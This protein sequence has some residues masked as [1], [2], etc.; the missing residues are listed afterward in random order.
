MIKIRIKEKGGGEQVLTFDRD[1]VNIGRARGNDIVLPRPNIS[2][3]HARIMVNEGEMYVVDLKSTNGTYVNGDRI[4]APVG[5][6]DDDKVFMGDFMLK[7]EKFLAEEALIPDEQ[8]AS[9]DE[10]YEPPAPPEEIERATSAA[11]HFINDED[12]AEGG[13]LDVV[14]PPPVIVEELPDFLEADLG[15]DEPAEPGDVVDA[16]FDAPDAPPVEDPPDS[17]EENAEPEIPAEALETGALDL[18]MASELLAK[19]R[20]QEGLP[21]EIEDMEVESEE[22][23]AADISSEELAAS[24][25][26]AATSEEPQLSPEEL[27]RE[28]EDDGATPVK[29]EAPAPEGLLRAPLEE[30]DRELDEIE[31]EAVGGFM[32]RGDVPAQSSDPAK[33]RSQERRINEAILLLEDE[34]LLDDLEAS[35]AQLES[36]RDQLHKELGDEFDG[37]Q[38]V[39]LVADLSGLGA[40]DAFLRDPRWH[41]LH[42]YG[43]SLVT[44]SNGEASSQGAE[45]FGSATSF[46]YL[47]KRIVRQ[48]WGH[49]P[50]AG[51]VHH[52]TLTGAEQVDIYLPAF[53]GD[54]PV[55]RITRRRA[56]FIPISHWTEQGLLDDV[57][58]EYLGK[59]VK[60]GESVLV[61]GDDDALRD[62]LLEALALFSRPEDR[63]LL[64]QDA[65]AIRAPQG[66]LLTVSRTETALDWPRAEAELRRFAPQL[67]VLPTLGAREATRWLPLLCDGDWSA[68]VSASA[69]SGEEW[70]ARVQLA[71]ALEGRELSDERMDQLLRG[72]FGHVVTLKTFACGT[73]KVN[74]ILELQ[75]D[76][77]SATRFRFAEERLS[78]DGKIVGHFEKVS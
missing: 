4:S 33:T 26:R 19:M 43:Y 16:D 17:P 6:S 13:D 47:L 62:S 27:E 38:V 15:L 32:T 37:A 58:A 74:G 76:G 44:L 9:A 29:T 24:A 54:V 40:I 64:A 50:Q 22:T 67:V 65:M 30:M 63:L 72:V 5:V 73:Q 53:T 55:L 35:E 1:T 31:R 21:K 75:A 48:V 8:I 66:Q 2:K 10:Y 59:L 70:L 78:P 46:S 68:C 28:A 12:P 34:G 14:E 11:M 42:A 60:R 3:R 36:I 18:D 71:Y 56:S 41:S 23:V 52:G 39:Q 69:T 61:L 45:S 49:D 57:M 77:A 7:I 20:E 51:A 25:R